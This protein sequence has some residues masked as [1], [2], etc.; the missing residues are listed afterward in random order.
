MEIWN[1]LSIM[2]ILFL[3][4]YSFKGRNSVWGMLTLGVIVGI[5]T[6]TI[7]YF[8]GY[9]FNWT[10]IKKIVV[11]FVLFAAVYEIAYYLLKP[12][13]EEAQLKDEIKSIEKRVRKEVDDDLKKRI[14]S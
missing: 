13:S 9:G 2:G 8:L 12:K 6:A 1:I 4:L 14:S 7:S 11:C 3:I 5:I 10:L